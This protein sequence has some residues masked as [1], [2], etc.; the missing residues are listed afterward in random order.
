MIEYEIEP[1]F[2]I[3]G[4]LVTLVQKVRDGDNGVREERKVMQAFFAVDEALFGIE[5]G[6]RVLSSRIE[7]GPII[8]RY[9]HSL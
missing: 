6:S 5:N 7:F 8:D 4:P 2:Q 3:F 1:E 9:G